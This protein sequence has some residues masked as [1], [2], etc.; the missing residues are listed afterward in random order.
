MMRRGKGYSIKKWKKAEEAW[1]TSVRHRLITFE[2]SFQKHADICPHCYALMVW[3]LGTPKP[4][5]CRR[6][7][8]ALSESS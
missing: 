1:I 2:E 6:C 7:K 3:D 4:T 8:N 5:H